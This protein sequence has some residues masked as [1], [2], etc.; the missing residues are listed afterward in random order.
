MDTT[1]GGS[2]WGEPSAPALDYTSSFVDT[3]YDQ[4]VYFDT[5][6]SDLATQAQ[7]VTTGSAG[8]GWGDW[9]KQIAGGVVAYSV[10]KDA[11]KNGIQQ[12][13]NGQQTYPVGSIQ[14]SAYRPQQI[15]PLLLLA[16]AGLAIYLA[17]S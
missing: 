1:A 17:K 11:A 8:D 5:V 10:Q 7:A 12:R 6:T 16:G 14:G 3:S 4:P 15:S 9:F 13:A 2:S